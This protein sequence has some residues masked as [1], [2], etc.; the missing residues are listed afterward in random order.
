[1]ARFVVIGASG[2]AGGH[3]VDELLGRGH[4]VVAVTRSGIEERERLVSVEGSVDD[5][6][7]VHDVATGATATVLA[8]PSIQGETQL[9][10]SLPGILEA[11]AP[12]GSR[13]AVIGGA[14]SLRRRD[15]TRVVDGPDFPEQARPTSRRSVS[16]APL[17]HPSTGSASARQS[18]SVGCWGASGSESTA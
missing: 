7:L 11:L 9:S 10:D 8:V 18:V 2:Y 4:E 16:C 12:T 6:A 13:L 5:V 3:L 14:G 1:M 15:G 17:P